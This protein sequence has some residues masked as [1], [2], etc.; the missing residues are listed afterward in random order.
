MKEILLMFTMPPAFFADRAMYEVNHRGRNGME[1]KGLQVAVI[2]IRAA[3]CEM[4]W[5][6]KGCRLRAKWHGKKRARLEV[7]NLQGC[8]SK[9]RGAAD[10]QA[11]ESP[12]K[13]PAPHAFQLQAPRL[14]PLYRRDQHSHPTE[15]ASGWKTSWAEA[16]KFFEYDL[17]TQ[18][19]IKYMS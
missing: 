5:K 12:S 2:K 8:Y 9:S 4:A 15:A 6:E 19:I 18:R 1:R 13:L 14:Q 17:K 11:A 7:T 16:F 3:G 10:L